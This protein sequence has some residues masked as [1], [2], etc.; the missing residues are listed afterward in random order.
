MVC[1]GGRTN[2]SVELIIQWAV[3][4]RPS[5][6]IL[7]KVEFENPIGQCRIRSCRACFIMIV[8]PEV[9]SANSVVQRHSYGNNRAYSRLS[10]HKDIR[11]CCYNACPSICI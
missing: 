7:D 8:R 5:E 10:P 9:V 1:S 2:S 6:D 11:R 4:L 3:L